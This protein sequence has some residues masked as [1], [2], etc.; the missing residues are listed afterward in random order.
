MQCLCDDYISSDFWKA[1]PI[2]GRLTISWVGRFTKQK[3]IQSNDVVLK[4]ENPNYQNNAKGER[5][6]WEEGKRGVKIKWVNTAISFKKCASE[7]QMSLAG[8]TSPN[9]NSVSVWVM[10]Q[11][12]L[13]LGKDL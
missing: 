6:W 3:S 9:E 10:L 4:K 7:V 11:V 8:K 13:W 1:F 2:S 12:G 5:E